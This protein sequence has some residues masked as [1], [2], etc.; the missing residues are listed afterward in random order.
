MNY[1]NKIKIK[2]DKKSAGTIY[3]IAVELFYQKLCIQ[4]EYNHRLC[5]QLV[6]AVEGP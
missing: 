5:K 1:F 6:Q 3:D 2:M 4:C